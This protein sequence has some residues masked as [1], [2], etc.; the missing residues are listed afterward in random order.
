MKNISIFVQINVHWKFF[1]R[2]VAHQHTN[3][4]KYSLPVAESWITFSV[5]HWIIHLK[6]DLLV[7][8]IGVAPITQG[9]HVRNTNSNI[10]GRSLNWISD[11]PYYKKLLIKERIRSLWDRILSCK[12]SSHFEKGRNWRESLL[13]LWCTCTY[14]FQHSGLMTCVCCW[15]WFGSNCLTERIFWKGWFF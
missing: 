1:D 14:L 11:F 5:E 2:D 9:T 6:T 7:V 13:S 12:R 15:F 4:I 3:K 10:Q 8:T